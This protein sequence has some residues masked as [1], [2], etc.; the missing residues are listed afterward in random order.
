MVP[1]ARHEALQRRLQVR[2]ARLRQREVVDE[3]VVTGSRPARLHHAHL[4]RRPRQARRRAVAGSSRYA[5]LASSFT[6]T[7]K[8]QLPGLYTASNVCGDQLK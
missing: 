4:P 1:V 3:R 7:Q 5:R 8:S 6:S 2:G